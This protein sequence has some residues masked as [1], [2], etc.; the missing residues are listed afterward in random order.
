MPCTLVETGLNPL[1]VRFCT[2]VVIYTYCNHRKFM[3]LGFIVLCT[4]CYQDLHCTIPFFKPFSTRVIQTTNHL[5]E[6]CKG[7]KPTKSQ[8]FDFPLCT[9]SNRAQ[10]MCV[11]GVVLSRLMWAC[12]SSQF[13]LANLSI[14]H[15]NNRAKHPYCRSA[16][17]RDI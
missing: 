5:G 15:R 16:S 8:P 1:S 2:F 6:V 12:G 11:P 7:V 10:N 17:I 9:I 3:P 4:Y 14:I 13:S